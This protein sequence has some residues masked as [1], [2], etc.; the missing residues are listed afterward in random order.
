MRKVIFFAAA[1]G[2]GVLLTGCPSD[3]MTD[4]RYIPAPSD[5]V[6]LTDSEVKAPATEELVA[7]APSATAQESAKTVAAYEPMTDAVPSGGVDSAAVADKA[8]KTGKAEGGTYIVRRGDTPERIARRHKVKLGDLMQANNL[9][10][11]SARKLRIGQKLIIPGKSNATT[12]KAATRSGRKGGISAAAATPASAPALEG[13]KYTVK[14]GDT[15]ERIARRFKIKLSD[16][17]SANSLDENSARKLQI[18]QK[19]IIPGKADSVVVPASAPAAA[20]AATPAPAAA[21]AAA[22]DAANPAATEVVS[23]DAVPATEA[24]EQ[25]DAVEVS[26]DTTFAE[27]AAKRGITE[28]ELRRL[29]SGNTAT[30]LNKGD[31]IFVPKK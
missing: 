16:L 9:D 24:T 13:G 26:E 4:R 7:D 2:M 10:Q 21:E 17:L 27:F 5:N 30:K 1:A 25:I 29:N 20:P 23:E 14:S 3:V 6:P 22:A 15:P 18:G 11:D 28:E 8:G 19:L 12:A 31:M